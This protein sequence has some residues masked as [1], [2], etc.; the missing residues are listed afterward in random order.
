[1]SFHC[2]ASGE[3]VIGQ[4]LII[5]PTKIRKVK[6]MGF[7]KPLKEVLDG[8][9]PINTWEG[10]EAAETV[11]VAE[12]YAKGYAERNPPEMIEKVKEIKFHYFKPRKVLTKEEK[13]QVQMERDKKYKKTKDPYSE[14]KDK[15]KGGE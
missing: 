10:W 3:V 12:P 15:D 2:K 4:R 9:T 8:D 7:P 11:N 13:K 1:M 5:I 14:E 6:Y